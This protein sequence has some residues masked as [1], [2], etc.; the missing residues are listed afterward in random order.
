MRY[1]KLYSII[2]CITGSLSANALPVPEKPAPDFTGITTAGETISLAGLR[3]K[4]VVLEWTNHECPYV[5]KHYNTG[6]MQRTQSELT[7]EGVVWISI[8]SSAEGLQGYVSAEKADELTAS[9]GSYTDYVVLDPTGKIGKM[10]NARTTPQMFLINKEG[11]LEYMGAIDDK[12]SARATTIDGARNHL[13]EAWKEIQSGKPVTMRSTKPY[14]C[15]V[16]Y[17]D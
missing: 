6:N 14:G 7:K 9:R 1:L 4:N 8:I 12:P 11:N 16:K 13:L 17:S 5:K 15:S 10:Y 3:G 2:L